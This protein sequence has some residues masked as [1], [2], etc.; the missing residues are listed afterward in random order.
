[1]SNTTKLGKVKLHIELYKNNVWRHFK[2]PFIIQYTES[3][4]KMTATDGK[5]G[6]EFKAVFGDSTSTVGGGG[7][8]KKSSKSS[9][10][11][12][13]ALPLSS[14]RLLEDRIY[15]SLLAGTMEGQERQ[16]DCDPRTTKIEKSVRRK[17]RSI[18]AI[19]F[20]SKALFS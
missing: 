4:V 19:I 9:G 2:R 17:V 18:A 10:G 7:R 8:G 1:M 3:V 6:K 16:F 12:G 15:L 14:D 20:I 13:G 5:T 11:G